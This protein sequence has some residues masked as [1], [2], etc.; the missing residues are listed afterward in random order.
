MCEDLYLFAGPAGQQPPG[1]WHF[2][3]HDCRCRHKLQLSKRNVAREAPISIQRANKRGFHQSFRNG[4][5]WWV[6]AVQSICQW[7]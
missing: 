5:N 4:R 6:M 1:Q 7:I 3:G 2:N